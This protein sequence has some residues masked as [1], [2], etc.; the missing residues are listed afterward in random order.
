M[1]SYPKS[2]ISRKHRYYYARIHD[3]LCSFYEKHGLKYKFQ[4][5]MSPYNFFLIFFLISEFSFSP[6]PFSFPTCFVT[7]AL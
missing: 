1:Q 2:I 7:L 4:I 5:N 3:L 6:G